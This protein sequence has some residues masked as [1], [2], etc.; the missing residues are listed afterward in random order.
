MSNKIADHV[1]PSKGDVL[2][3]TASLKV[4]FVLVF[5]WPFLDHFLAFSWPFFGIFIVLQFDTD[6]IDTKT[7][8]TVRKSLFVSGRRWIKQL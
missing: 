4:L 7:K 5:S 3:I 2:F 6:E 1:T 8:R